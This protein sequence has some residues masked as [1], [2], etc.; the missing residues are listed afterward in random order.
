MLEKGIRINEFIEINVADV[1]PK[2]DFIYIR[3]SKIYRQKLISIYKTMKVH[4][5]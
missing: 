5:Y 2:E 1:R 4:C 3:N